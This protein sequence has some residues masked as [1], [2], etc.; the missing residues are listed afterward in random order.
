MGLFANRTGLKI[1][2]GILS[3]GLGVLLNNPSIFY[4]AVLNYLKFFWLV[5]LIVEKHAV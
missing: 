1:M 2:G 5:F 4:S 3:C